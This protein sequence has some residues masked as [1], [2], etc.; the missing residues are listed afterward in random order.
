MDRGHR[1]RR[2]KLDLWR[3]SPDLDVRSFT[4]G[5]SAE[6]TAVALSVSLSAGFR[7]GSS[8]PGRRPA[9]GND[10]SAQRFLDSP[11]DPTASTS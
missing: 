6:V 4:S 10:S 8:R 3:F 11:V 1:D 5:S 2:R 7:D 9:P